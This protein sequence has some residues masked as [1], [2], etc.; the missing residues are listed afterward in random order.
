MVPQIWTFNQ[1]Q[2]KAFEGGIGG[3][4]DLRGI[5]DILD[6]AHCRRMGMDRIGRV[7]NG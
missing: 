7:E 3:E 2:G 1:Y 4:H 5:I 6:K